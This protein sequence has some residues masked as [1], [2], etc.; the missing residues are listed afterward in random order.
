VVVSESELFGESGAGSPGVPVNLHRVASHM[1]NLK[2][3]VNVTLIG[4]N[5]GKIGTVRE[6]MTCLWCA[7]TVVIVMK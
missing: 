5:S 7:V 6:I 3:S 2:K 4:E 1:E